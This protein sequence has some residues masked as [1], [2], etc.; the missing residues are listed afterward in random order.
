ML[1]ENKP[2]IANLSVRPRRLRRTDTLRRMVRENRPSVDNFIFPLFIAEGINEAVEIGSMPGN[3]AGP[4]R[5]S[6]PKP[7]TSP[8]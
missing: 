8:D 2:A 5:K 3:I 4:S 1:T 6:L 7:K